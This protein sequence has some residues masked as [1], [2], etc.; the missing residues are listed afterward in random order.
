MSPSHL[1][2]LVASV[3]LLPLPALAQSGDG[4]ATQTVPQ[5]QLAPVPAFSP[6]AFLATAAA[7]NAFEVEAAKIAVA[8]AADAEV[9]AFAE[10]MLA[11]H[12]KAQEEMIAAAKAD[13]VEIAEPSMDGEQ[14]G[15]L[16]KLKPAGGEVFD[17]L[18]V[19]TQV[20]A[21]QRAVALF[22][23]YQE[24]DTRLH[25]FARKALP[26]LKH[27]HEMILA[28]ATRLKVPIQG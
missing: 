5:S 27:H 25:D 7:G 6:Y 8:K 12:T 4:S 23:G 9:K 14:D 26:L 17:R 22:E 24:G 13:K 2:L 15:M 20:A 16:D 19:E 10:T 28:I 18:Y 3:L 21:H 1:S 11:D